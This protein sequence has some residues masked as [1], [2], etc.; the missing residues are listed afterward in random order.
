LT[1]E[2]GPLGIAE[3]GALFLQPS[4]FWGWDTPQTEMAEAPGATE[5]ETDAGGVRLE[6][7]ALSGLLAIH[8]RGRKLEPGERELLAALLQ[9]EAA[10]PEKPR[11]ILVLTP[12]DPWMPRAKEPD[13]RP[14]DV[15][16]ELW[17]KISRPLPQ[18]LRNA[19]K[20]T[21]D[22]TGV[23]LPADVTLYPRERFE[24]E[25]ES[26]RS[27]R[28]LVERLGGVEPLV[29]SV[30]RPSLEA[31]GETAHVLLHVLSTWSGCGGINHFV[32]NRS[33]GGWETELARV[34]VIW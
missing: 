23:T 24:Q 33:R 1:Y 7:T 2:A 13:E 32:A 19:N 3:G 9:R 16:P 21:Y 6:P 17:E 14:A 12:T 22:L 18:S 15:A 31:E 34:L 27:L 29:L 8:V 5:V 25:Y 10:H 20:R 28:D 11:P 26:E 30:S 4:P